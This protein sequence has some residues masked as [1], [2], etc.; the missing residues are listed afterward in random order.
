VPARIIKTVRHRKERALKMKCGT[1]TE[2]DGALPVC[3]LF[4][5]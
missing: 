2:R 5:A 1:T 3:K 4:K